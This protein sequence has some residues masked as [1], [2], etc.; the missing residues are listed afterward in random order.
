M[1]TGSDINLEEAI[2]KYIEYTPT[3]GK[4]E[5]L[6][7][8]KTYS[9]TIDNTNA[10]VTDNSVKWRIWSIDE[11]YLSIISDRPISAGGYR[12]LGGLNLAGDIGYNNAVKILNDI[13][14][15]CYS[16][17]EY[18]A[19]ARSLNISDIEKVLN[20]AVWRPERYKNRNIEA[21]TYS[22]RREYTKNTC[23]PYIYE[24]EDRAIIDGIE[25][26]NGIKSS[27][28]EKLYIDGEGYRKAKTSFTPMQT[29]WD[30]NSLNKG[31]FVNPNYYYLIFKEGFS[32]VETLMS[33]FL[34]SRS[35]DLAENH[36]NFGVFEVSMGSKIKTNTLFNSRGANLEY[37][38]RIR[39]IVEIPMENIKIDKQNDGMLP[40]TAW[41]IERAQMK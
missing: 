17:N 12:N 2:G 1:L 27:G 22:G 13:A 5:K 28:Q 10:F 32:E 8:N 19:V 40:E 9:G 38:D 34:A 29:A 24:L 21:K 26:E 35:V 18:G 4:Y 23:Y 41:K 11:K 16:N 14:L 37:W 3:E 31:N 33:Y 36:V 6:T 25:I 15:E 20:I 7:S 30:N 39:P